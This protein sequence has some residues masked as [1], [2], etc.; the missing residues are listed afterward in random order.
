MPA[1]LQLALA[2]PPAVLA[3]PP[4]V[5]DQSGTA[6]GEAVRCVVDLAV[7][8]MAPEAGSGSP[9]LGVRNSLEEGQTGRVDQADH[10][11][12][13]NR[14]LAEVREG[15]LLEVARSGA[16]AEGIVRRAEDTAV[17]G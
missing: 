4:V 6:A 3:S 12:L 14:G 7:E 5:L 8:G 13:G 1:F 11:S 10:R 2:A 16:E 9:V 15:S 17:V